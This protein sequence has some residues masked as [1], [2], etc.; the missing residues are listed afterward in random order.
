MVR[1]SDAP[2]SIEFGHFSI[3]PHRRQLL[4]DGRPISL[5]G[6]AFDVLMALIEA[7]GAVVSKDELLSR[8]WQGRIVEE[9]RLAGEIVAL[10]KALGANRELIRTVPGR[11]Y[12]FTGEIRLRPRGAGELEVSGAAATVGSSMTQVSAGSSRSDEPPIALSPFQNPTGDPEQRDTAEQELENIARSVRVFD[13]GSEPVG[14]AVKDIPQPALV[15]PDK[16]SI[17]VLPCTNMSGDL[18]QEFFADGITE[19]I[20]TALSH[21]PSLF[22]VA[23]NSCFTYKGRAVDVKQ[24]G[25]ELG[26]RYVLEGSLRK[27]NNRIRVTA[28]LVEAETGKHVW[29]EHYDRDLAEIFALQDEITEAVTTAIAPALAE[30]E[31][32]RAMRKPPGNL[33]AWAAYQ[34]GLWHV[35]KAAAEDNAVAQTFF[36]RAINLDPNFSGAYVGLAEAQ[37][38]ATDFHA[39]DLA[40]TLRSVEVLARRAVALDGADAEARSLLAHTLWRRADYEGALSEVGRALAISPNLAYA[41]GTLGAA[42]IFSGHPR[43]GL[44]ALEKSIRLDPRDPRSAIRLNQRALGLYFS[45]EYQAAVGAAKHAIRSYPDFPNPYR[46]LAAALGQLGWIEE[47]KDALHKA[48]AVAP[49]AFQSSVHARVPWMRPQDH[50]HMLEGLREACG[51]DHDLIQ[52][53][54]GR[55]YQFTGEV[56]AHA[57]GA[58]EQEASGAATMVASSMTP[59]SSGSSRLDEPSTAVSPFPNMSDDP[60][61]PYFAHHAN[62]H[63]RAEDP[64]ACVL[65]VGPSPGGGRS[66]MSRTRRLAGILAADVAGYSRLMEADEESTLER[67]KALR[68][69]LIDPKIAEH[70]GRIVK[71]SGDGLLVEFASVVD[72]LRCAIE[73]QAALADRNA[74]LPPD[75]RIEFRMGIHQGD[76]V[77]ENG[78]IFGDG[79]NIAARLEGLAEPGGICV[80][81]RVQE[82]AS[83]RLGVAFEDM[84]EQALKNIT[85]PV[86]AYRL[87]AGRST[88]ARSGSGLALPDK[89][90]IAVLP[91]ENMS[92][93]PGQEYFADGMVEEIITAL[94]RIRWLFVVARNSSFVYKGQSPDVKRV[95]RELGVRYVL[96]GSVRKAGGRVRITAQLIDAVNGAHLWA[97]HFDGSLKDVFDL[98]DKVA[99]SVAGVIEPTLQA[100]ETARSADRPTNDLTAYDLYLRAYAMALSSSARYAE[101]LRL[102]ESAINRDPNYGPALAWAAFCCHRLLLDGRSED[103]A[104]DRLKGTAFA[105]RAVE[106]AGDDPAILANAAYTLGYLGEDI[107]AMM[108]LADRA[109]ALNPSFAR[110]WFVSGVLRLYAGQPDIAI[111]HAEASLRLSPRARVGWALLTIGAAHFYAR[112]FD[113]AVPKLLLAIQEDPSLPNPYRYLA[114]CY[115]HMGRLDE[116]RAAIRRLRAITG[117]VIPDLTYLRNAEHRAFYLAGLRLAAG[118]AA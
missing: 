31:Q 28:Q 104:A 49:A 6:R 33:D 113:E 99:L 5:G 89:P 70:H 112:R 66:S 21:Y 110:G 37:S 11:G 87:V 90:S 42:L 62:G 16:P 92:D 2:A 67:L 18:E 15:L 3:L 86:R 7:S 46:W 27:A 117:V 83:G 39:D 107:G 52:T 4:V 79:V 88:F 36:R 105:R 40:E 63:L 56:L 47:A 84:G 76:I 115:A 35:G 19:D 29:A 53:L 9:N 57:E 75:R 101:A 114:A 45:R 41:H 118:E 12:Q 23:R 48:M 22:V 34:R 13:V 17:A 106:V 111:E 109:L 68:R 54:A 44:A 20:I 64:A 32:Q 65:P 81:A 73:V 1:Q 61:Q 8:A 96:E 38:Q 10:R 93:D 50:A 71:T 108:A 77:V 95:G 30:A 55:G 26:V 43:E 97:D 78:D 60:E 24:V 72:A 59:V 25:C 74:P 14:E 58:R 100:A 91:F 80:T 102:L 94:S 103:P 98:Q 51:A 69:E 116:A 85:R 82:D